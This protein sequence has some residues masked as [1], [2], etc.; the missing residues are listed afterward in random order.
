MSRPGVGELFRRLQQNGPTDVAQ[1]IARRLYTRLGASALEFPLLS[2]DVADSTRLSGP[3]LG[4]AVP[5]DGKLVIAWVCTPPAAGSGGHTTLFRMVEAM[6]ERGH[7]CI[8]YLYDRHGGELDRH[9]RVIQGG[10]PHLTVEIRDATA[11]ISGVDVAVASS[12][13]T[14]HV[15]AKRL[16]SPAALFYFIQDFEPFFY[17][18]GT[19]Q[20][21]AEDSYRFGFTNIALGEMVARE[22][23][24]L[25]IDAVT[26]PFGCDTE[27]YSLTNRGA[28]SGVVFY[29][30][31]G[32][33]RRGF[34]LAQRAL[35]EFHER[36]PEQT[37]HLYGDSVN[38]WRTPNVHHGRLTPIELNALY[39]QTISGLAMSFTNISLVAEEMLAAG[40][41]PI[42]NDS[43]YARAD[44][45]NEHVAWAL[46]TAGG[47]AD[48]LSAVVE[49][50]APDQRSIRAAASV[51]HGW[52]PAQDVVALT[53]EQSARIGQVLRP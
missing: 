17:P 43:R 5:A 31:P 24:E 15:L 20:A 27:V 3:V 29:A 16:R 2:A 42:V 21:L 32:A 48:A 52:G 50:A 10:W 13:E 23:R 30:K 37:I 47:I 26:A 8:L 36:H 41:I 22:L 14:A 51:R 45:A 35:E 53:I 6:S 44:L 38:Y 7:R 34:L 11:G 39:N 9:A 4:A 19:L 46:P 33:D 25:D 28:R 40:T 49:H 1:R 12:W 18:R